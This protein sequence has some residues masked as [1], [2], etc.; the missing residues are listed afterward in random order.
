ME[1]YKKNSENSQ[2]HD[3]ITKI[4]CSDK[5]LNNTEVAVDAFNKFCTQIVTNLILTIMILANPYH[6]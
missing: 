5:L 4:I 3:T 2:S 6:Y 1:N